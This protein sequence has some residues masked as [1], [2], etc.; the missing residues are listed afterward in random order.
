MKPA[1]FSLL[2]PVALAILFAAALPTACKTLTPATGP[3]VIVV[4]DGS[5]GQ[6]PGDGSGNND[7]GG[8]GGIGGNDGDS[9]GDRPIDL[10]GL[11]IDNGRQ[12]QITQNNATVAARYVVPYVCDH[13]DGTGG[14]DSTDVDFDATLYLSS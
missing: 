2:C 1:K 9:N 6:Q 5:G 8:G 7:G 12:V 13:R 14:T 4:T 11:W 3:G 10:N